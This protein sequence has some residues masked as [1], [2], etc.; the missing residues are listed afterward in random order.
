MG[1][2]PD[3]AGVIARPPLVLLG[4]I[5]LGLALHGLWP[6]RLVPDALSAALGAP[7]V[8]LGLIVFALAVRALRAA[9]TGIRTS[10]PTTAL[11]TKG[12][13]RVSRN[14]IYLS[15]ALFQ[16]G[17]AVWTNSGWMLAAWL[18]TLAILRYGVISR[19]EAYLERKFGAAY[20]AYKT[21]ARR[22]L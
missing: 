15:F 5:L 7:L 6:V 8:A 14:P 10:E 1:T 4:S 3:T 11:T 21:T 13:Y 19:E 12:P 9:G 18:G 2:K 22:W 16:L 17:L 20:R